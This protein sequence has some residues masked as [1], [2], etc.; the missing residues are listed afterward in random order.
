MSTVMQEVSPTLD[1]VV[2]LAPGLT[3]KNL[4]EHV[5]RFHQVQ[6]LKR[7]LKTLEGV[8][9]VSPLLLMADVCAALGLP[10]EQV[11]GTE[12]MEIMG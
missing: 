2:V 4:D 12:N 5:R 6:S 1:N 3:W 8:D 11:I 7:L 9:C 10:V